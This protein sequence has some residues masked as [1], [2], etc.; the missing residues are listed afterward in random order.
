M[1]TIVDDVAA[2]KLCSEKR[3]G[4]ND[5]SVNEKRDVDVSADKHFDDIDNNDQM[6]FECIKRL[7]QRIDG[8]KFVTFIADI[9]I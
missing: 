2:L 6:N 8:L 9:Y 7:E 5:N 4:D 3:A 1:K